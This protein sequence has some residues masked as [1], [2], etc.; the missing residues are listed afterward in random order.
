MTQHTLDVIKSRRVIRNMTDQPVA[1]EQL[2]QILEA[3]RWAPVGGNQRVHRYVAV[4]EPALIKLLTD[5][6][7][8]YVPESPGNYP[9]LH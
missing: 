2:E 1:R 9:D 6:I 3:G 4:Q 7:T 5:G 8:R